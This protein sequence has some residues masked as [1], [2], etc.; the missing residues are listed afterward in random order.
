MA[1]ACFTLSGTTARL[2]AQH[3]PHVPIIAFSPD[4]AIRRRIA[5]YWGVVPR[6]MEPTRNS[7][8]MCETV[9]NR[10]L[11][12]GL[13]RAGDRIVVVFGSPVGVPGQT[14]SVRL[15]EIP[16]PPGATAEA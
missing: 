5:L 14:N 11:A 16:R 2:L 13:A 10:L 8:V 7:D 1:I 12:D 9:S 3:R 6:V 15:H 4:Q